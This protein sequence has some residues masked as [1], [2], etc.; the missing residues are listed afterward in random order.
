MLLAGRVPGL[1]DPEPKFGAATIF[2]HPPLARITF[3]E[4]MLSGG[5]RDQNVLDTQFVSQRQR[6][7]QH[8]GGVPAAARGRANV[9]SDVAAGVRQSRRRPMPDREPTKLAHAGSA[10]R[11]VRY[12]CGVIGVIRIG[13]RIRVPQ[14]GLRHDSFR[15]WVFWTRCRE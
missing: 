7:G 12:G 9:V 1:P 5:T 11:G 3:S 13:G 8:R 2:E 14:R 4:A 15:A 6:V 10:G